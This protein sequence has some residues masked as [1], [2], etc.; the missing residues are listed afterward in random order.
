MGSAWQPTLLDWP[1]RPTV[2]GWVLTQRWTVFMA[3]VW[4]AIILANVLA[5]GGGD[6]PYIAVVGTVSMVGPYLLC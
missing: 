6:W 4:S 2:F 1:S 5:F 3:V